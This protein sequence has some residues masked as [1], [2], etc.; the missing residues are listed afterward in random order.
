MAPFATGAASGTTWPAIGSQRRAV[1]RC[2]LTRHAT[3]D[4]AD[5]QWQAVDIDPRES[6]FVVAKNPMNFHNVY[7]DCATQIHILDTAGPTPASVRNLPF[8]HMVRPFFPLD[9]DIEELKLLVLQ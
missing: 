7:D 9:S 1:G 4:W 6:Q 2:V 5:E 3:Y 8:Q